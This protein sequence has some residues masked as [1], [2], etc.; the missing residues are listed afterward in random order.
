[1]QRMIDMVRKQTFALKRDEPISEEVATTNEC[2]PT[3]GDAEPAADYGGACFGRS[4]VTNSKLV[5][6]PPLRCQ[7]H[8]GRQDHGPL[9]VNLGIP[10]GRILCPTAG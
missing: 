8:V 4:A 10:P 5:R 3:L 1:M 9:L 2:D 7:L 6:H